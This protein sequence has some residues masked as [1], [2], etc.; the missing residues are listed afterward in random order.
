LAVPYTESCDTVT[1]PIFFALVVLALAAVAVTFTHRGLVAVRALGN[2][3]GASVM[4][5]RFATRATVESSVECS[6]PNG[7]HRG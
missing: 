3:S 7:I 4:S 2:G 5:S 6:A 1:F